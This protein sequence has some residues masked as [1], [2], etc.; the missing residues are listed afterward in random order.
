M[1]IAPT[2]PRPPLPLHTAA[3][4]STACATCLLRWT[5]RWAACS[6]SPLKPP[7][8]F[9]TRLQ[10][11]RSLILP[12][13]TGTRSPRGTCTARCGCSACPFCSESRSPPRTCQSSTRSIA[14]PPLSRAATLTCFR[15]ALTSPNP[16][17]FRGSARICECKRPPTAL[18]SWARMEGV[19]SQQY[20]RC[21]GRASRCRP[22]PFLP[23]VLL[24][25]RIAGV[26]CFHENLES[27]SRSTF[28]SWGWEEGHSGGSGVSHLTGSGV[29]HVSSHHSGQKYLSSVTSSDKLVSQECSG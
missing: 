5:W 3:V 19:R 14:S 29:T 7:R 23:V 10:A 17:P 11:A 18:R 21:G 2:N 26:E 6:S 22:Q 9:P 1:N 20:R 15:A 4:R 24:V 27:E 25:R 16:F 8:Y 13:Q 12:C 28:G